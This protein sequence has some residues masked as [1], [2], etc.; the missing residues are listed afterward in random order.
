MSNS[1]LISKI[2]SSNLLSKLRSICIETISFS[3][4]YL[5]LFVTQRVESPHSNLRTTTPSGVK[6]NK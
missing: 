2:I 4:K 3:D 6:P 5:D 1:T